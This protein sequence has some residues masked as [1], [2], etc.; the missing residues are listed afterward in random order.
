MVNPPLDS[1]TI[2]I[3]HTPLFLLR[4]GASPPAVGWALSDAV[5]LGSL[6]NY[7]LWLA[8]LEARG[9][10]EEVGQVAAER[11]SLAS[12][13][14]SLLSSQI[15]DEAMNPIGDISRG[16]WRVHWRAGP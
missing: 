2:K 4:K 13:A 9:R 10:G 5:L 11:L 15:Y 14:V 8:Q 6:H 16:R 12:H 1:S 7:R 3:A